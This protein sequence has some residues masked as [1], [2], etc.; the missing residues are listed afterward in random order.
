MKNITFSH[1][2]SRL[3]HIVLNTTQSTRVWNYDHEQ[4]TFTAKSK[5]YVLIGLHKTAVI[6][7][8]DLRKKASANARVHVCS[9]H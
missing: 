2:N 3:M 6:H 4:Q 7:P 9:F 1:S 8:E 5:A